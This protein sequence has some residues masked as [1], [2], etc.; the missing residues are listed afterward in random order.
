MV[1]AKKALDSQKED[2]AALK[3]KIEAEIAQKKQQ[4]EAHQ[5]TAKQTEQQI[6]AENT[7]IQALNAQIETIQNKI[8]NDNILVLNNEKLIDDTERAKVMATLDQ[9]IT[10]E[11]SDVTEAI[12]SLQHWARNVNMTPV[13]TAAQ[14]GDENG[15]DAAL[16]AIAP[17]TN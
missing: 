8:N 11:T 16:K 17:A 7:A 14:K 2:A 4:V 1:S 15:I 9:K 3:Q 5:A 12:T 10:D 13:T 6:I